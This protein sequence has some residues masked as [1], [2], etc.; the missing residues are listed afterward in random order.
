MRLVYTIATFAH[1]CPVCDP[2]IATDEIQFED[3]TWS[4]LL[5][6]AWDNR[7]TYLYSTIYSTEGAILAKIH[8]DL[9]FHCVTDMSLKLTDG[10]IYKLEDDGQG[11]KYCI[12]P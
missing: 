3:I 8:R 11:K 7:N 12:T 6:K 1:G 5:L 10:S 4:D 2:V 9:G